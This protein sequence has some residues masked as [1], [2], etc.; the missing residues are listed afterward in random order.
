[1]YSLRGSALRLLRLSSAGCMDAPD[2]CLW[3]ALEGSGVDTSRVT[4][5]LIWV[6][7]MVTL[8]ITPLANHP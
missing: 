2:L 5:P 4:S 7:L 3:G 6:I 8:L 1:M